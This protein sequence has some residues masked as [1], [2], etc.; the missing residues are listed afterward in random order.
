MFFLNILSC[1]E[2]EVVVPE[3][4]KTFIMYV[5]DGAIYKENKDDPTDVQ[6]IKRDGASKYILD[7]KM[8]YYVHL[9]R[10]I[11]KL[12]LEGDNQPVTLT[13]SVY[14]FIFLYLKKIYLTY[15]KKCIFFGV[16]TKGGC[17]L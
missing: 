11:V 16:L 10:N 13:R 1:S 7:G 5:Y 15:L 4:R 2:D 8:L 6:T 12:N 14:L 9:G 3:E 17:V